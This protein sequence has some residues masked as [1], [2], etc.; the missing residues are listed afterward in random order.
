MTYRPI[1]VAATLGMALMSGCT[2]RPPTVAHVHIGHAIT[3]VHVTPGKKGYIVMARER[4]D[5]AIGF[6]SQAQGSSDLGAIKQDIA[7]VN[8]STNA[9]DDF[10]LKASLTMAVSHISFAATSDDA[11]VNVQQSAPVFA[12]DSG[13]VLERCA[14]IELLSKDVANSRS[15]PE[16]R[17]TV[18]EIVTLTR[19]NVYGDASDSGGAA[20]A[21]PKQYGVMQ[22]RAELDAMI[23][24]ERPRYTTVDQWYLFNL[25]RLPNGKW[26][27]DKLGRG[28]TIE[29]Y[30]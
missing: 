18:D 21:T 28:G 6:A 10:G 25:V 26:V 1:I 2:T 3:G 16:A 30:K 17:V 22:L 19:A 13:R 14:L 7:Q 29:G 15:V 4:A 27:F 11:S 20:G 8:H 24:R 12:A 23:G 9:V 5:E